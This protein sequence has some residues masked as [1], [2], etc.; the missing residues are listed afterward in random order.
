MADEVSSD[1]KFEIGHVLFIDIVGYSKLRIDEQR[2]WLRRLRDTV[3][4]TAPVREA[5]N[6]QLVRLPTGDGMALVFRNSPEE[7]VRCALEIAQALKTYPE[8]LVRM[9]VHSGP[10]S[11][12]TDLNQ[13]TNVAGAGINMAQR[14]MDCGD[15]G[16]ILLSRHVAEDLE[17][18][19][20]WQAQLH[21]L[22]EC[23]VK[24]G[25]RISVVNLYNDEVGNP[26][27]PEKFRK[28]LASSP[29]PTLTRSTKPYLIL[30][31]VGLGAL[32]IFSVIFAI[33]FSRSRDQTAPRNRSIAV[34]PF[35]N[36][37]SDKENAYFAEGIQD[38]ILTR[39]AK[40][41]D[42]KV[43]SRT[44]TQKYKSAPNNSREVGQQLGVANLL[45]G[46]VQ[47]I[48]NAVHINVQ[49]IR[50]ATD[51]HVWAESYNRKLD[52][53][54]GVEGEVA[55]AIADQL[56]AK[57]T[58]AEQKAITDKPTQ[59]LAAYDAYLRGLS[60]EH[61]S[62]FFSA[63]EEAAAA[64]ATAV[65]LDP[66]FALAWARLAA[67]RSYLYFNG[68]DRNA[69]SAAAVKEAAD[70]AIALQP[71]LGEAW[72]AEGAYRYRVQRDYAGAL[73]TYNE[74]Q[75][76]LPNSSFVFENMALVGRR[77]GLWKEADA[78]Y[79]KAAELDP[80]DPAIFVEMGSDFLNHLRR[81]DEAQAALDRAL[82]ISPGDQT[83]I[84]GKASIFQSQGRLE[85]AAKELARIPADS[86]DDEIVFARADQAI[87]ER[88]F[89]AAIGLIEPKIASLRP[90]EAVSIVTRN[91]LVR[92][93]HCQEWAGQGEKARA[94]YTRLIQT[95]KPS[96]DSVVSS[97]ISVLPFF[98]AQAYAGLG[99]KA[100]ALDQAHRAVA[101]NANDAIQK[102]LVEA[103]L[104]QIQARFGDL[105]S[106]LAVLP[107]LLEVPAGLNP[108]DLRNDPMWDPLRK[109]PRFQKLC[110]DKSQ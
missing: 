34:L 37:S 51:E 72:V 6:E 97:E 71:E 98:L 19:P 93:G 101:E 28:T 56:N 42:L 99:E 11:E 1:V 16:H 18:Y 58:G 84:V 30:G 60:I 57:L 66:K 96:A 35:D 108:A 12:V 78:Y 4:A 27:V 105:D 106:A 13:R 7:P 92:L 70:R 25:G 67:A 49:L 74:A 86:A 83:A 63:S 39:L 87:Y 94:T 29:E 22:G 81:F 44:S 43:I 50:A 88:R 52:D 77:L 100:G 38:E 23:E 3:L 102:P 32:A 65:Q 61:N 107:H 55:S 64:Y 109:D 54:F 91:F 14:V 48:A 10:V 90:G 46:S 31:I 69:N 59:N 104:A 95:L 36:L 53:V 26:A 21:E 40:I 5:T 47:K 9:G 82:E 80:R 15:A 33:K 79:K 68:I 2:E 85:E 89:D 41:A 45:E 62:I 73:Q 8:V 24:H 76:R 103:S 20:R 110:Q 75:K 17:H